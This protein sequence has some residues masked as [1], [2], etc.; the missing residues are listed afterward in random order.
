MHPGQ[1]AAYVPELKEQG[2]VGGQDQLA[3]RRVGSLLCSRRTDVRVCHVPRCSE[4][5][6]VGVCTRAPVSYPP[7]LTQLFNFLKSFGLCFLSF[8]FF[9]WTQLPMSRR[10]GRIIRITFFFSKYLQL[11]T[12][13]FILKLLVCLLTQGTALQ[14]QAGGRH[15]ALQPE[16][17][18]GNHLPAQGATQG[19]SL[20]SP[21][22]EQALRFLGT[23]G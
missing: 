9:L 7:P 23:H 17:V 13:S 21:S 10:A 16:Q 4:T 5:G 8:F 20:I 2:Q 11:S 14:A 15:V 3:T 18:L 19:P 12:S 6:L 22:L 1:G